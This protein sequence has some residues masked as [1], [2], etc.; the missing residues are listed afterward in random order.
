M[1]DVESR[2]SLGVE[3]CSGH[4]GSDEKR[5]STCEFMDWYDVGVITSTGHQLGVEITRLQ[6]CTTM[7]RHHVTLTLGEAENSLELMSQ[8]QS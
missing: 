3:R 1:S 5:S 7:V 4:T 2:A 8:V 6:N